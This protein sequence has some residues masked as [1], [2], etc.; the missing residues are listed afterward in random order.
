MKK[1]QNLLCAVL[2]IAL[3]FTSCEKDFNGIGDDILD[4][5]NFDGGLQVDQSLL[6]VS[7]EQVNFHSPQGN[8]VPF[9]VQTDNLS[10]NLLGYYHDPIYGGTTNSIVS[11]VKLNAYGVD[12]DSTSRLKSVVI[13]VP[14][15]STKT[16]TDA[17]GEGTYELDSIYG[18]APIK[19]SIHRSN[20]FLNE[21]A[22]GDNG[23]FDEVQ[24]FY[25]NDEGLVSGNL[26]EEIYSDDNFIPIN[27][28]K[29]IL[30]D[31]PV[32]P[33]NP[34]VVDRLSPRLWIEYNSDEPEDA[35][36]MAN[37]DWL[38]D[39]ANA[40]VLENESSFQDFYRGLYLKAESANPNE[41]TLMGLDLSQAYID[42]TYEYDV[43]TYP[44]DTNGDGISDEN[45]D[46]EI[47]PTEGVVKMTFAGKSVTFFE[48]DF[49]YTQQPDRLYLKGGEGTM[50][51]L[52]LF[53]TEDTPGS[54]IY[55]ELEV[56]KSMAADED[57]LINE[58][59]MQFYVDNTQPH[60][61]ETEPERIM[62]F[63]IDNNQVLLDYLFDA[64]TDT[65]PNNVKIKH[66]GRLQR[67]DTGKGVKYDISITEHINSLI[68][69]DSTNVRLGLMLSNNISL[70]GSSEVKNTEAS[71]GTS[72]MV[73]SSSIVSHRGTVLYSEDE[74]DEEKKLKLKIYYTK[75]AE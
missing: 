53:G 20:Y 59:N 23:D 16:A 14:Y 71:D 70:L 69:L 6:S 2:V 28:E 52:N 12:F 75:R 51:K 3:F 73:L 30:E 46:P 11:Q 15:Y 56:L 18:N 41:G 61:S 17:D 24:Q 13:A 60:T 10:Y 36:A 49:N 40:S 64:S 54:G 5:T 38:L 7:T 67:D 4:Q 42:I 57:W 62:L 37:F 35:L 31:D 47:T 9:P 32:D 45:D 26:L 50:V 65:D 44:E 27:E 43:V 21:Y 29:E 25:S 55:P 68:K 22:P 19:L 58:A 39:E 8:T 1:T 74:T 33:A 34:Q 72:D 48:N 66:L 63:D